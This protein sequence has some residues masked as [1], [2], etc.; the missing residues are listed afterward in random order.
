[1]RPEAVQAT[2]RLLN[3][4]LKS[5]M[6]PVFEHGLALEYMLFPEHFA[7]PQENGAAG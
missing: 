3:Q 5:A 4:W 7:R 1:M 2:K 6:G